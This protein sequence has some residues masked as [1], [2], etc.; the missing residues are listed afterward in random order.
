[1]SAAHEP[2]VTDAEA[3]RAYQAHIQWVT[4]HEH[5]WAI[6]AEAEQVDAYN[7]GGLQAVSPSWL[8]TPDGQAFL[9]DIR[10][11]EA[12]HAAAEADLE[13]GS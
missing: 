10:E 13:A 2:V 1:M 7:R 4:D 11:T 6:E 9:E 5:E 12:Q 8:A 3:D